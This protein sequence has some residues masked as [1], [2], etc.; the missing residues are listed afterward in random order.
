[1]DG[2]IGIK[3]LTALL[4]AILMLALIS[5]IGMAAEVI[6]QPGNSIQNA[7]NN[8]NPGDMI[9][10]KP[11]TYTGNI[12]VT[13]NNLTIRSESGNPDNTILKAGK[14]TA[15]V[16]ILRGDS[17]KVTG[18]KTTGA[19]GS[20]YAGIALSSCSNCTIENNKVLNNSRGISLSSSTKNKISKNSATNNKEYG[21]VLGVSTRNTISGNTAN[22]NTRGIYFGSSDDNV[23]SGNTVQYSSLLGFY[24]CPKSDRNR[25][26]NNYFND[27]NITI[28]NGVGNAYNN[29]RKV[30]GTNII[31]GPYIGGNF[32]AK[33]DG[34]GF[35]Q[36]AVDG[37]GDGIS[38][39]AYNNI[40]GSIYS[41]YMPLTTLK[42]KLAAN[43]STNVTSGLVPLSVLFTDTSTGTPSAWNWSFGDGTN[44]TQQNPVHVYSTA[45][46]YTVKLTVTNAEGSNTTTKADYI[47]VGATPLPVANFWGSPVSGNAPLNVTFKDNSTGSP[48][49]WNWSFGDGT[50]S[51]IQNP[52]HTYST[53]GNYTVKLTASNAAG[54]NTRTKASY[55][56]VQGTAPQMPVAEFS[57]SPT[58]GSTPLNV[59]FTDAST[60]TPT[61]WNWNFGDGVNSTEKNPV[62]TYSTQGNYTVTLTVSNTAGSNT[63]TKSSYIKVTGNSPQKPTAA[64]LASPTSGNIPLN[65]TFTD[66]STG[67]PTAWSW[68]FG[69]GTN[70]A[71]QNPVHTYTTAG[72]YTVALTVSNSAGSNTATK[73][74][75]ITA[76]TAA[77]KPVVNFWGSPRSGN[78]T[79]NVT[80]KDN[81]TGSPTSWNWSFGDGTYSTVQNPKHTYSAAGNY[82]IKLTAAN[83]AGSNTMTKASYIKVTA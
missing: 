2:G 51:T 25:V 17:I 7:V 20:G 49:S 6:I 36:T 37:D 32:W 64:F 83:S 5:G 82:T 72:N 78:A 44:S 48:T 27:N 15:D 69:D 38:D 66:T 34:T 62:H 33:P 57:A 59:S 76:G 80:F 24:I 40:T 61:V 23:L 74:N 13:K 41:D 65:V 1:M 29:T 42:Q 21:I 8:S 4:V 52:K 68:S 18:F 56:K 12:N 11:G 71:V 26:Y 50:Y 63:A 30:A 81:T 45:G 70:S 19:T 77:Q 35:S 14:S 9:T 39:S 46:N 22:N 67:S 10:V 16:L 73:S 53:A 43:F 47:K 60:G 79:L 54:N 58:S 75:Y 28:K 55:I 3:K 31:G